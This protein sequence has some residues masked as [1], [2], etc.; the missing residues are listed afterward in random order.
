MATVTELASEFSEL[1]D[2]KKK[3]DADKKSISSRMKRCEEQL[4]NAMTD[5]GMQNLTL[6][7]GM[8][9][10]RATD[11]FYGV[12]IDPDLEGEEK[13]EAKEKA[14]ENLA[15]ELARHPQTMDLVT[16][17][18]NSRSLRARMKEIE[19]NEEELPEELKKLLHVTE[20]FRVKYR[21]GKAK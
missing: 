21:S 16:V 19:D 1:I 18:Y 2:Q 10:Y 20:V 14:K 8:C 11:K 3:Q 5:E 9:L 4:L 12:V 15:A 13:E 6:T 17:S 7:S